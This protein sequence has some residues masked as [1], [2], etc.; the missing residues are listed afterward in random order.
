[1]Y[2]SLNLEHSVEVYWFRGAGMWPRTLYYRDLEVLSC[3]YEASKQ[4]I[5]PM[6][7]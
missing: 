4:P 2:L 7:R 1:M 3:G 5:V 6:F